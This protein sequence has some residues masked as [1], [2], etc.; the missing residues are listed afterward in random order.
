MVHTLYHIKAL[1]A[2]LL[3]T[4]KEMHSEEDYSKCASS[5]Y[6]AKTWFK[7]TTNVFIAF[8]FRVGPKSLHLIIHCEVY[9]LAI[10]FESIQMFIV[11]CPLQQEIAKA[12][13]DVARKYYDETT[14][15]D[16]SDTTV[17]H[18]GCC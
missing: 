7:M 18:E 8:H 2:L 12:V 14:K 17:I 1:G 16:R 11:L 13:D 6:I 3:K 4:L 9:C 5:P 15:E 10:I